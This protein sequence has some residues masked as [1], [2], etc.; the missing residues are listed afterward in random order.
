MQTANLSTVTKSSNGP[1]RF[2]VRGQERL[3]ASLAMIAGYVDVYGYISYK[4]Y[5]S[6]MGGNTTQ[7]GLLVGQGKFAAAVPALLAIMFFITGVFTGTFLTYSGKRRPQDLT[8]GLV[9]A[10]LTAIIVITEFFSLA[11]GVGIALLGFAMGFMNTALSR[12]GAQSI[13]LVFITGTL[14]T[15]A[16]HLAEAVK[17][18]PLPEA[19]GSWDTHRRRAFLLMGLWISFL[20]GSLLGAIATLRFGVYVLLLP[21]GILAVFSFVKSPIQVQSINK[22]D[23]VH[24]IVL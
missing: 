19:Q 3:A 21:I 24:N 14:N 5:V 4:T 2:P 10:M 8:F 6:F 23:E 1:E 15:M 22:G 9:A 16:Q 13:N 20:A 7:T 12:I 11:G 17:R 18:A